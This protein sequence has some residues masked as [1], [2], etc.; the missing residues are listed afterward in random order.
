MLISQSHNS[1]IGNHP[2]DEKLASYQSVSSLRQQ[3]EIINFASRNEHGEPIWDIDAIKRRRDTLLQ[4]A[5]KIW[6]LDDI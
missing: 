3:H 5:L 4:A 1:T 6:S 2:F